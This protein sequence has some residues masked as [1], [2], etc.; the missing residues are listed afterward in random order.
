ML[1]MILA[2]GMTVIGCDNGNGDD[3]NG[4][5]NGNVPADLQGV[6]TA[7]STS[8]GTS[9]LTKYT[10]TANSFVQTALNGETTLGKLTYTIT[11]CSAPVTD[12]GN[13]EFPS[14]YTLTLLL[15]AKEGE[16]GSGTVGD[17]TSISFYLNTAKNKLQVRSSSSNGN[18]FTK[19][20][21]DGGGSTYI[22][23]G[24]G[25]TFTATK[26]GATVGTGNQALSDI[27]SA[28]RTDANG[29]NCTI[30]FGNGTT[31][32][33]V[34][35]DYAFFGNPILGGTSWGVITITGKIK[36]SYDAISLS[37]GVTVISTADITADNGNRALKNDGGTITITSGTISG[38]TIGNNS[39]STN[40]ATMVINGGTINARISNGGALTINNGTI[41]YIISV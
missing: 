36:A 4:N 13:A 25:T 24:S 15:T 39:N 34:G 1:V 19:E 12:N 10:F 28:I 27:I 16:S 41:I 29:A 14:G 20:G 9:I 37:S 11:T 22:I 23:T 38:Y 8:G 32:L 40:I 2:F 33:D 7:T 3:N 17:S 6:W 21:T 18:I 5:G 26:N 30:Q 31:V 35:N